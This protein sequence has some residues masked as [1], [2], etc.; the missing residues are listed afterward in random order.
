M[1]KHTIKLTFLIIL[2]LL[3]TSRGFPVFAEMLTGE[4]INWD[5]ISSGGT[6]G[7]STNYAIRGTVGQTA[8]GYGSSTN[9][10]VSHGYWHET[11]S[12]GCCNGDG[13]R[14]NVDGLVQAGSEVNVAD[15]SYLVEYLFRGGPVPPCVDEGNVNGISGMA[16]P[17]DVSD[18]T[19]LVAYLFQGGP[20][21]MV[22][23]YS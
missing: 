15:L 23:P 16:G 10:G 5:V 13:M 7:S 20:A 9:Y 18:L 11:G 8:V 22:C 19:Y 6:F 2:M 12:S 4:E 1:Y 17:I 21:P 3:I 14:G